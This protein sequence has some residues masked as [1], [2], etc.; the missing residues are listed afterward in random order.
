M[1]A[2]M[3][4]ALRTGLLVRWMGML[5]MFTALLIVLPIGGAELQ[6]VPAFWMVMMGVLYMGRW[7]N[8]EPPA[9]ADGEARPWPSAAQRR[10][11][12]GAGANGG[13]P[14]P[15]TAGAD[16]APAPVRASGGSSRKRRR[17][18]GSRG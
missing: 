16:V 10:A 7:P 6:V 18:R 17:K 3:I 13:H 4:N 5:G 15:A 11:E 1:I 8:A 2:T 12:A 14:A 9:W